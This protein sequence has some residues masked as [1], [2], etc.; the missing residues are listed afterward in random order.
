MKSVYVL[1]ANVSDLPLPEQAGDILTQ[2]TLVVLPRAGPELGQVF[3][4]EALD[5]V[6]HVL[7][8]PSCLELARRVEAVIAN[9][10]LKLCRF[11]PCRADLPFG[12]LADGV[13][14]PPS[15]Q[16][17]IENEAARGARQYRT[18]RPFTFASR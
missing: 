4:L 10:A 2:H 6:G 13:N 1:E 14:S 3:R 9:P 12:E 18:P 11:G 5:E 17:V 8:V 16:T 15:G 7:S